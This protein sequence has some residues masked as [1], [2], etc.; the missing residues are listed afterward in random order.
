MQLKPKHGSSDCVR[1]PVGWVDTCNCTNA[2]LLGG[3]NGLQLFV[4]FLQDAQ[5]ALQQHRA[6]QQPWPASGSHVSL[7]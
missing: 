4:F 6:L 7:A 5:L 3:N 2:H 1:M